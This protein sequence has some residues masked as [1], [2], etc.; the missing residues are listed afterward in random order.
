MARSEGNFSPSASAAGTHDLVSNSATA[1]P[2]VS[3]GTN[4]G[5]TNKYLFK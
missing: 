5:S 1:R 3:P 2:P 4:N